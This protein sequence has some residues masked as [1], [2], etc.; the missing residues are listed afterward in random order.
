[1]NKKEVVYLVL[2]DAVGSSELDNRLDPIEWRKCAFKNQLGCL[3]SSNSNSLALKSVGD[4]LFVIYEVNGNKSKED[5]I[6]KE[7][8]YCVWKAFERTKND[9]AFKIPIRCAIHRITD[10][11]KGDGIARDLES[12]QTS[13]DKSHLV[14]ALKKD[15]FGK[16][17]NRA[18]RILSLVHNPTILVSEA[19]VNMINPNAN[20]IALD[21]KPIE[22]KY[23][24]QR[25]IFHSPVPVLYMKGVFNLDEVKP[26][27]DSDRHILAKILS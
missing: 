3:L 10:H 25:L 5:K 11:K 21:F 8:L 17:V 27:F 15:I 12:L 19:I 6:V 2:T 1:M 20:K 26:V 18:A 13:G 9:D 14:E 4:A 24:N 7:I 22:F 16:E 23:N